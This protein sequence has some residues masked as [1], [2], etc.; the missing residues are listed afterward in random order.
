MRR[1]RWEYEDWPSE[2]RRWGMWL[3]GGIALLAI[4]YILGIWTGAALT[5][6]RSQTTV[7]YIPPQT[8][9]TTSTSGALTPIPG[10]EDTTI[11]TQI[12]N[13]VK[14]ASSPSRPCP[15]ANRRRA[16]PKKI[17]APAFSSIT[18]AIS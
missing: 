9:N 12:Y 2:N 14:T 18:M 1:R 15:A 8:G 13:R 7:E 11:V 10:V 17:S 6:G 4:S 16:T 3:A 5:R